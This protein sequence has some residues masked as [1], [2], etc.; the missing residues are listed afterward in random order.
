MATFTFFH[1]F[2][3]Y[4]ADGTID[5]DGHTFK[6]YL[7]NDAPVVGT[8]TI[9]TDVTA[10]AQTNGYTEWTLTQSWSETGAGTGIWRFANNADLSFTASGG[11][12][13]PFQYV[14]LYDD[15]TTSPVDALV[16]YLDVGSA[17]TITTGNTFTVDLDANFSF[18][19]LS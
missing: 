14:V 6:V 19:T 3:R 13:G 17:T 8:D 4:M 18:F 9:K 2:K 12:V 7:S 10:L 1:E 11:S 5:L 16:G 15:T